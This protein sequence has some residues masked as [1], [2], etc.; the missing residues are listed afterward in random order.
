MYSFEPIIYPEYKYEYENLNFV[1]LREKRKIFQLPCALKILMKR[2]YLIILA[3][4]DT[5]RFDWFKIKRGKNNNMIQ[6]KQLK[7]YLTGG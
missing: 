3:A 1:N 4:L 2:V 7:H 5:I 6:R